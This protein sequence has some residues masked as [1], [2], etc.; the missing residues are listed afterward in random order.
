MDERDPKQLNQK[1]DLVDVKAL[2]R[3]AAPSTFTLE[4]ILKEYGV[5]ESGPKPAAAVSA[6]DKVHPAQQEGPDLPW[7]EAP[8]RVHA[9]DNGMHIFTMHMTARHIAHI[10]V[11][12]HTGGAHP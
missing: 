2:I 8:K 6:A 4:D 11:K 7:P 1:D 10:S 5:K 3:D 12:T 9:R